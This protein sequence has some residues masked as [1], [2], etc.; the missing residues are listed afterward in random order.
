[1]DNSPHSRALSENLELQPNPT[2]R[3]LLRQ[4]PAASRLLG[5]DFVTSGNNNDS[6]HFFNDTSYT[7]DTAVDLSRTGTPV[8]RQQSDRSYESVATTDKPAPDSPARVYWKG[9]PVYALTWELLGI[10]ISVLFLILGALVA[11]LQG[12]NESRWSKQI[13]QATRVAPSIW[14]ILFSGV[15][16]N[17]VRQFAHWRVERGIRLLVRVA[18]SVDIYKKLINIARL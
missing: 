17:A 6:T 7:N 15:L 10:V 2:F 13:V 1:M 12:Q 4:D 18:C 16:G 11:S 14:P 8:G 3:Q 5:P 9:S